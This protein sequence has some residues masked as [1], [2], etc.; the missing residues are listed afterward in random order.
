MT[1]ATCHP[2]RPLSGQG[3]C[4]ACYHQARTDNTLIIK[5][6][7]KPHHYQHN[8]QTSLEAAIARWGSVD[9]AVRNTEYSLRD[10]YKAWLRLEAANAEEP[11]AKALEARR[12]R[13]APCGTYA[14]YKR[15]RRKGE[16]P[17]QA[18]KTAH[19]VET[20][21]RRLRSLEAS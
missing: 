4:N 21:A 3:L 7:Q 19:A 2:D 5:R 8:Q 15:H 1:A 10:L 6:Q 12:S 16:T 11:S 17:D 13:L 20:Q 9:A 18:C 14:A